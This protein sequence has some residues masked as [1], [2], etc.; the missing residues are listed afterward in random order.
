MDIIT[1]KNRVYVKA[2]FNDNQKIKYGDIIEFEMPSFCSGEYKA[3]IYIDDDG[4]PYID[5][6]DNY[7]DGCRDLYIIVNN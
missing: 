5:K 7:Y 3:K 1:K 6:S 2:W 4:D